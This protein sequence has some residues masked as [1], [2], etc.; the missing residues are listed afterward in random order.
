MVVYFLSNVVPSIF[1]T[2][3][4]AVELAESVEFDD[5]LSV[6]GIALRDET[7][8]T[9]S[10]PINSVDYKVSDGSRVAMGDIIATYS[11]KALSAQ[12]QLSVSSLDRQ[13]SLLEASLGVTTQYDLNALD[14]HTQDSLRSFLDASSSGNL[15]DSLRASDDLRS[16]F[17]RRDI[18]A[19][20]NKS[21]YTGIL[22]NCNAAKTSIFSGNGA[23]Q[24]TVK[25]TSAGYFS[26]VFDGY[27]QF[28]SED[29]ATLSPADLQK[30]LSASP[31]VRPV[32]FVGKLQHYSYWSFCCSVPETDAEV[33]IPGSSWKVRFPSS[34][35]GSFTVTMTVKYR[36][37]PEDGQVVLNLESSFFSDDVYSLRICDAQIILKTYSGFQ[38]RKESIRVSDG[39]NGVY[40][41]SGAK[42]VFKPVTV[43]YSDDSD[44]FAVV[45][46]PEDTAAA[47]I[48]YRNDSVI[49]G[50]KDIY[51]GKIV[52][53]N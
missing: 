33:L 9:S 23:S 41:L 17:I 4:I 34:D 50:G 49:V 45:A 26:S 40:V 15:Q 2:E 18:K 5:L 28:R 36:S 38:I 48:L 21:Y 51:D 6:H 8:L 42:L 14:S 20:N 11:S 7:M 13:I 31:E 25:A 10:D 39:A 52:N 32:N 12:D 43:L 29:Y 3:A 30:L 19:K 27:E 47:R 1:S 24:H 46:V 53:I 37:A 35:R 22:S 16:C 44:E